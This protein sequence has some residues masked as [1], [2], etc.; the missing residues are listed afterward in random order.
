MN[1]EIVSKISGSFN[2]FNSGAVFPLVNGQVWQQRHYKYKYKYAYR[3]DV[4]IY[5]DESNR[6]MMQVS[7]MDEPIEV[8]RAQIVE[9]GTI[10]SA[11]DGFSGSSVFVFNNGH[12]WEQAEYKYSYHY[13]H[14]PSALVVD[15]INGLELH[16]EGMNESVRVRR[17]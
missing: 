9:E 11:F 14:R 2:G 3:P 6:W 16:V 4:K 12:K 1:N 13:S 7:V 17:A 8:V 5:R 10:T 15:G